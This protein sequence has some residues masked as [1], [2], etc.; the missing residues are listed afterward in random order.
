M[1]ELKSKVKMHKCENEVHFIGHLKPVQ[2]IYEVTDVLVSLSATEGLSN[3]ILEGLVNRL[4]IVATDVGGNREIIKDEY[5]G[6]LVEHGEIKQYIKAIKKILENENYG[7][8]L[9]KNG[10]RTIIDK[11]TFGKRIKK[12]E[13][14]Y[15]EIMCN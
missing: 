7:K 3:V 12:V 11:F 13:N 15:N 10:Y 9:G 8:N 14:F 1:K 6:L 5:S 2:P 4:P